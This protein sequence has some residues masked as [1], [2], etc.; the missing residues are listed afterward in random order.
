MKSRSFD[1]MVCSIAR[2]LE[3]IGDRWAILILRDLSLGLSRYEELRQSSGITNAT[4]SDR[5]KHLEENGLVER[6]QYQ[7]NPE[8][9][10]Y[11]LTRKGRD[12]ML[13][14]QA[15]VQIGDKWAVAEDQRPPLGFVDR[16]TGRTVKLALVDA[17][18]Q[19]PVKPRD[20]IPHEG[21]GADDLIRWRLT[22]LKK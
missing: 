12:T 9:Y 11:V 10:E 21:P 6:R 5:L 20:V 16:N 1:G 14:T 22:H 15:L 17:L 7:S 2:A 19:E 4:L 3:T 13:L 8:R 18:T